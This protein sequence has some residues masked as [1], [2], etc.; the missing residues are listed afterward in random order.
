LPLTPA[1]NKLYKELKD[2][3]ILNKNFF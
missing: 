1:S 3:V 2:E